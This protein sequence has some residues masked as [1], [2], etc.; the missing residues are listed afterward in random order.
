MEQKN[1]AISILISARFLSMQRNG[2]SRDA[3]TIVSELKKSNKISLL[4]LESSTNISNGKSFYRLLRM[5]KTIV[6]RKPTFYGSGS[7]YSFI[8]QIDN[9]L[10]DVKTTAF[11]RV[12]D[13][14][15]ITNPQ[16]SRFLSAISF[17][18]SL[19]RAV[20]DNHKFICNSEYTKSQLIK[21][22]PSANA[23]VLYCNPSRLPLDSCGKCDFCSKPHLFDYNYVIAV[24][25]IEPRK[26]YSGLIRA[27]KNV[28]KSTDRK[29]IVVGRFGWKAKKILKKLQNTEGLIYIDNAC[30]Y[31]VNQLLLKSKAFISCSLDEGF[32]FPSVDA[33]LLKKPVLLS[34]I[35]VHRE[36]HG[37][38]ATYFNPSS[39]EEIQN[40]LTSNDYSFSSIGPDFIS[41]T[42]DFEENLMKIFD[43]N[44]LQAEQD[45]QKS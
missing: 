43:I 12:H 30:D 5:I 7:S 2:I 22:Y 10:P 38:T 1:R 33:A 29:L 9:L 24:G 16:W 21:F 42:Q 18:I 6:L 45:K 41:V 27:W 15:P 13:I 11:I 36:L 4:E 35:P 3:M 26:N 44:K 14:F 31:A 32:D 23:E 20:R 37:E 28:C 39:V 8:P 34:D 25:T 19:D 17:K 40:I